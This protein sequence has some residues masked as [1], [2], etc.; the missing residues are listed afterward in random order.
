MGG[1]VL[2]K[3]KKKKYIHPSVSVE[4]WFQDPHGYQNPELMSLI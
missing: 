3:K 4:D 1:L 2:L